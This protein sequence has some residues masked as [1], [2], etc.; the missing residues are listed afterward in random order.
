MANLHYDREYNL[1]VG[2]LVTVTSRRLSESS[3]VFIDSVPNR[4]LSDPSRDA[5]LLTLRQEQGEQQYRGVQNRIR[6]LHR[7]RIYANLFYSDRCSN[8]AAE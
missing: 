8:G 2:G 3:A 5:E 6:S 1:R 4:K 7:S